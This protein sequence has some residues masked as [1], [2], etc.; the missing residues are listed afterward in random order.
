MVDGPNTYVYSQDSPINY[1]DPLGLWV[2]PLIKWGL[3]GVGAIV[4]CDLGNK[5]FDCLENARRTA[6]EVA[7]RMDPTSDRQMEAFKNARFGAECGSLCGMAGEAA[8]E[9]VY[10]RVKSG[11]RYR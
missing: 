1:N 9:W 3:I 6:Q 8:A 4:T 11:A 7:D 10:K 2:G 5:C